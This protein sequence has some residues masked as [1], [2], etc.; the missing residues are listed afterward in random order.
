M[1]T[2][3][4]KHVCT[5]K[6]LASATGGAVLTVDLQQLASQVKIGLP[7][8][9]ASRDAEAGDSIAINGVCLTVAKLTNGLA[10]FD[11][12]GETLGKTNLGKLTAGSKVNAELALRADDRLGG[13]FVLGHVDGI[14][15]IK[16]IERKGDFA[17]FTFTAPKNLL[18]LMLPKG[19]VAVDGV[20]LTI[21][22]MNDEG[23]MVVLIPQTLKETTLGA[24]KIGQKVNV[25]NDIITKTVKKHLEN[26][27][28][29]K[30]RLTVDKLKELGF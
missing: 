8:R 16:Q 3:I 25:E 24:A 26:I 5:V 18:D 10:T 29:A 14:A 22:E 2:G 1:F 7:P 28:L 17:T 15:T 20:S 23:F 30:Q 6:S 12:S 9:L 19:S 27:G 13:H 21:A 4:I 11:L